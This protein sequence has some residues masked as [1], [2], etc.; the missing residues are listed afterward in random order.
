M[1]G[2]VDGTPP[3]LHISNFTRAYDVHLGLRN[4]KKFFCPLTSP[5]SPASSYPT[6]W[7]SLAAAVYS[8]H[9]GLPSLHWSADVLR[10]TSN[11]VCS[12]QCIA[13]FTVPAITNNQS[14]FCPPKAPALHFTEAICKRLLLASY[15]WTFQQVDTFHLQQRIVLKVCEQH[16]CS[17]IK[18]S[19]SNWIGH[20]SVFA[21]PSKIVCTVTRC[22]CTADAR[23]D[24]LTDGAL[25]RTG[26]RTPVTLICAS[27]QH[28]KPL[29]P[30]IL[31]LRLEQKQIR[32]WKKEKKYQKLLKLSVVFQPPLP[33]THTHTLLW[34]HFAWPHI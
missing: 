6:L 25:I 14:P 20:T 10:V 18:C 30:S 23:V 3:Y 16:L 28:P 34:R 4:A 2:C 1:A 7:W 22:E 15:I 19:P 24:T 26:T 21:L 9:S 33:F 17:V 31:G 13:V 5:S 27:A 29:P 32:F 12:A 11:A 8:Q